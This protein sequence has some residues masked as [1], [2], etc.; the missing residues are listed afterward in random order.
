MRA[1]VLGGGSWGTALAILLHR[2]GMET[3]LWTRSEEKVKRIRETG[4]NLP[5]LPGVCVPREIALTTDLGEAATGAD[6]IVVS[7][8]SRGIADL[9]AAL[10]P[11][12]AGDPLVV[13]TSK[14]FDPSTGRR[15]S[16]AAADR[17][18][19]RRIGVLVGPSHAEE[20][21]R[22]IPTTVVA[23]STAPET[24]RAVQE[25]F[26][27][28]RFRVYT[29][30][31]LIGVETATAL[32]NVIALA[33]GVS[34]GLGFGDNTKGALLTRG[35]AEMTRLGVA[36]GGRRETFA[37]L[38]GMG[39]LVTTCISRHSRNR[40]FGE[41]VARGKPAEQVE[42]ELVM[43]AEGVGTTRVASRLAARLGVDVPITR[44]MERIL[45]EGKDPMRAMGDLMSRDPKAEDAEA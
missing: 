42:R 33:A 14:G 36:L 6:L 35:L 2:K 18:P 7:I 27:T 30:R 5:F 38:A 19:G 12:A 1:A 26:N 3:V 10:A 8:P 13:L 39:D 20:V 22:S 23:A 34:D 21:A 44:E 41:E 37:G 31:D 43:V 16:E 29:N 25:C 40:R 4:E 9:A 45:F 11:H 17:L 24:A 32:K 28:E 15:L